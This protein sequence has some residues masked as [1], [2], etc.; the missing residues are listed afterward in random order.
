MRATGEA[1]DRDLGRM[2]REIAQRTLA[3]PAARA[4]NQ[5]TTPKRR[6]ADERRRG[7]RRP[8]RLAA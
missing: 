3:A 1:M 7:M 5:E 6:R 4:A 2:L 8:L